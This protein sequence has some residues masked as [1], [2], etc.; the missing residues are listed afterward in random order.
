[1]LKCPYY[2]SMLIQTQL[3]ICAAFKSMRCQKGENRNAPSMIHKPFVICNIHYSYIS[4]IKRRSVR[5]SCH[6]KANPSRHI[7]YQEGRII[8]RTRSTSSPPLPK[9]PPA[10]IIPSTTMIS[11]T[12]N[13]P[14]VKRNANSDKSHKHIPSTGAG[15]SGR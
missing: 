5:L 7:R 6:T 2:G 10:S 8:Q 15:Y 4:T 9:L 12:P 11:L 1:M 13:P 3:Q 14:P